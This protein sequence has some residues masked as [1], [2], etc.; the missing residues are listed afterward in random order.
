V[1]AVEPAAAG[2]G[3]RGLRRTPSPPTP[4]MTLLRKVERTQVIRTCFL[5]QEYPL[6]IGGRAVLG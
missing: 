5:K 3:D 6:V 2:S 1:E 4:L